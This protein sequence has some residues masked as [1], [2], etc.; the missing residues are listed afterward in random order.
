M[1]NDSPAKSLVD[2]DL[3]SLRAETVN[4]THLRGCSG[5]EGEDA[6]TEFELVKEQSH[7][8]GYAPF[9]VK[10]RSISVSSL[11][12]QSKDTSGSSAAGTQVTLGSDLA[13]MPA[14]RCLLTSL[15]E[16]TFLSSS[17]VPVVALETGLE[18]VKW[19]DS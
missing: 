7:I 19:S 14:H 12:L 18:N 10:R 2:I 4:Q 15:C 11:C 17:S 5:R 1:A 16:P 8:L 9:V 3:A 6:P 13:A